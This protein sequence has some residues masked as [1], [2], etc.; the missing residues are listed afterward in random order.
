MGQET[1][2]RTGKNVQATGDSGKDRPGQDKTGQ[3]RGYDGPGHNKKEKEQERRQG[4]V[5]GQH[6]G[7][8]GREERM[9]PDRRTRQD[10]AG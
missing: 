4:T 2:D 10:R 7:H 9:R 5:R 8:D 6:R 1:S 3:N